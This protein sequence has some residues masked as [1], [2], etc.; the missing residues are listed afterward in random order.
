[1]CSEGQGGA[2]DETGSDAGADVRP[3]GGSG[4]DAP[5]QDAFRRNLGVEMPL[6]RK[7]WLVVRNS[8]L[9]IVRLKDCC[10]H[11]GEPGC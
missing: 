11:H 3:A 4:T 6:G 10:G 2:K 9:K 8:T 7:S 5:S 1:M